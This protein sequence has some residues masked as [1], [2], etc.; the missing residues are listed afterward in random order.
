MLDRTHVLNN[1]NLL[2]LAL[3]VPC[4]VPYKQQCGST[5]FFMQVHH[6]LPASHQPWLCNHS[7][8]TPV[9]SMSSTRSPRKTNDIFIQ[10]RM[11]NAKIS[12]HW[13]LRFA[14]PLA[15][16]VATAGLPCPQPQLLVF[17]GSQHTGSTHTFSQSAIYA[18]KAIKRCP[19]REIPA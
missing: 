18:C 17:V 2:E 19:R 4:D 12:A 8:T 14:R 7:P 3:L 13:E 10:W 6:H 16:R 15:R 5:L 11:T 9:S 1:C